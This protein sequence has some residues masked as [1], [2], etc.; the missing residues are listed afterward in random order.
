MINPWHPS[1]RSTYLSLSEARGRGLINTCLHT[2]DLHSSWLLELTYKLGIQH[3]RYLSR[4]SLTLTPCF[5]SPSCGQ[6]SLA[7]LLC[8][9]YYPRRHLPIMSGPRN[10]TSSKTFSLFNPESSP[11]ASPAVRIYC[12]SFL[13]S[14]RASPEPSLSPSLS[15][16]LT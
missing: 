13:L 9:G 2:R 4:E 7:E 3:R 1:I 6:L 5:A 15:P 8:F 10:T 14:F 11:S 12:S 16:S